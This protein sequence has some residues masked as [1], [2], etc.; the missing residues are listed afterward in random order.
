[1]LRLQSRQKVMLDPP[2]AGRSS[3][4]GIVYKESGDWSRRSSRPY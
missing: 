2:V 3:V 4:H 1:M